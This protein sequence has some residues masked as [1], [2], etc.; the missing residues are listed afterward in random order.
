MDVLPL[1]KHILHLSTQIKLT[2][3]VMRKPTTLYWGPQKNTVLRVDQQAVS[4]AMSLLL[5]GSEFCIEVLVAI[6]DTPY[7]THR[8]EGFY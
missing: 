2:Y 1:R 8:Q 6:N 3:A 4:Q 5:N 7:G